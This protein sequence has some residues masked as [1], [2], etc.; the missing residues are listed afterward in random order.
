MAHDLQQLFDLLAPNSGK[1]DA[2]ILRKT[3][4]II[5]RPPKF[6]QNYTNLGSGRVDDNV[7]PAFV[8]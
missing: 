4:A 8:V 6:L 1:P 7:R 5:T 3:N 2:W